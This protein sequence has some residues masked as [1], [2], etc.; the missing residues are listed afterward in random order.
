MAGF[1]KKFVGLDTGKYMEISSMYNFICDPDLGS[2][3]QRLITIWESMSG[4]HIG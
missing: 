3:R 4:V 2:R 1:E